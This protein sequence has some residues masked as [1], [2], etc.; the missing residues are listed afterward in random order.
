M[1]PKKAGK[2]LLYDFGLRHKVKRG[3]WSENLTNNYD[4]KLNHHNEK[5]NSCSFLHSSHAQHDIGSTPVQYYLGF[6]N[7]ISNQS[8]TLL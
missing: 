6:W 1:L 4:Y 3:S 5:D 8:M 7:Q 2:N